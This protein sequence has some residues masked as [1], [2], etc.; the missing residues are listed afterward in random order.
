MKYH[1]I[2][3]GCQMNL[4]DS[5][6]LKSVME[7]MGYKWTDEESEARML[8]ILACSVRQKAINKVYGKI[9]KW[10]SWKNR[11][12][13]LTFISG[14]I[15]P[16]DKLKFLKLFDLVFHMSELPKLPEIIE[17]YG[18]VTP[19]SWLESNRYI[20]KS[21]NNLGNFWDIAPKYNSDFEAYVP[22]Q[23]GCDKFCTFCAVPYTRGREISRPSGEILD[24]VRSLVESGYKSITLLGQKV[25]SY[26]LDKKG[27]E[28]SFATLLNKIGEFGDK[29]THE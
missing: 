14:C 18:I 9:Y 5:E 1:I 19:A 12:N 22:I 28:I 26:G 16:A 29:S 27:T 21:I 20:T 4:S 17:Q 13:V 2:T 23:N 10:N 24:E 15:L 7:G 6:R 11:K 25:N 3:L 8:G